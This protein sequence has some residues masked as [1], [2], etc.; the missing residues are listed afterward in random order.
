ME[1]TVNKED[2]R[3]FYESIF[4]LKPLIKAIGLTDFERREFG[5]LL[6]K[7]VF[8]RNLS[9][10]TLSDFKNFILEK[11][12]LQQFVGAVYDQGPT[13]SNP[14]QKLNLSYR[15]LIF[16]V[17]LDAY[18]MV[19]HCDCKGS[20]Q[21]CE[22]CWSLAQDAALFL[23]ETLRIDFGFEDLIFVFSGR[24][25]IHCWVRDHVAKELDSEQRSAIVSYL[26]MITDEKRSQKL[27][28]IPKYAKLLRDRVFQKIAKSFFLNVSKKDLNLL[29]FRP[30]EAEKAIEFV[31]SKEKF[32]PENYYKTIPE[33]VDPKRVSM[34]IV[35]GRYPRL[36]K[37][38]TSDIRRLL[39]IPGSVHSATGKIC[40]IIDS[41]KLENFSPKD[42]PTIWDLI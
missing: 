27:E 6:S 14:I 20:K 39:R 32:S 38:V 8:S 11:L 28:E 12:P 23:D 4:D 24:R 19:R 25:G 3:K 9:F 40:T 5:F 36:D 22:D 33:H 34:A 16:D 7:D 42:V 17:D 35:L 13:F 18:D 30:E 15:E 29:G 41:H 26:T 37:P 21:V 31:E 1:K 10:K 2:L